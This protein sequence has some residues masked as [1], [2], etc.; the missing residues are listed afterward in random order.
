MIFLLL[1]FLQAL[2]QSHSK[3]KCLCAWECERMCVIFVCMFECF[4]CVR[5]WECECMCILCACVRVCLCLS[6]LFARVCVC[7]LCLCAWVTVLECECAEESCCVCFPFNIQF[8]STFSVE[9]E[10]SRPKRF[11]L[12]DF[13]VLCGYRILWLR[14]FDVIASICCCCLAP[15]MS[16]CS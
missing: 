10:K 16:A 8:F 15:H 11:T 9:E 3:S 4:V 5:A 1:L 14:P 13:L 7:S 6:V 2:S 12:I